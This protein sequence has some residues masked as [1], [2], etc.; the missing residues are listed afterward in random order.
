LSKVE[1]VEDEEESGTHSRRP[2]IMEKTSNAWSGFGSKLGSQEG[3]NKYSD[4]L[5]D[6]V[7]DDDNQFRRSDGELHKVKRKAKDKDERDRF[8]KVSYYIPQLSLFIT[9]FLWIV[10]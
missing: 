10:E 8:I 7:S 1:E 9:F 6:T 4:T 3:S 5:S 2:S